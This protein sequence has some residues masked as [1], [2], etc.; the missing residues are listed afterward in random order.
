M[1]M[2]S[3][4][5]LCI[6]GGLLLAWRTRKLYR[7]IL[8]RNVIAWTLLAISMCLSVYAVQ[9]RE[10]AYEDTSLHTTF[11][12]DV[13]SSMHVADVGSW[14]RLTAAQ[15]YIQ[16]HVQQWPLETWSL[17]IFWKS[18]YTLVP[19][20]SDQHVFLGFAQQIPYLSRYYGGAS[21]I[22]AAI[23]E[24]HTHKPEG[25][26]VQYIILSDGWEAGDTHSSVPSDI[27]IHTIAIGSAQGGRIATG[28]DMLNNI[29]YKTYQWL[30]V[31]SK[32]YDTYLENLSK[33][34]GGSFQII[35]H[36][37]T[38]PESVDRLLSH[39]LPPHSTSDMLI[40]AVW[41][42]TISCF[43]IRPIWKKK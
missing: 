13:S 22:G 36:V 12:V 4:I 37:S 20:T 11:L 6:I 21:D 35:E 32:R 27:P 23:Q 28:H 40:Y 30:E 25:T 42:L 8:W 15:E 7:R 17:V 3:I 38:L 34:H 19:P 16:T 26:P 1:N 2:T 18:P 41:L 33:E 31:I 10:L 29:R 39:T 43:C 9:Q 24:A 5:I 14:S